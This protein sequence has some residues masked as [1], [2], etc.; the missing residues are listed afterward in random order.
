MATASHYELHTFLPKTYTR[1]F[2][3][4]RNTLPYCS[5]VQYRDSN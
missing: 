4:R 3:P 5:Q 1:I 2:L